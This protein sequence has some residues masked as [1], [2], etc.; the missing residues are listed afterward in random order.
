MKKLLI[1][2]A[3]LGAMVVGATAANAADIKAT[4]SWQIESDWTADAS[5]Q[6]KLKNNDFAI[7]QRIRTAFQFIANE[8][9]K[10]VLETQ[11]GTNNWGNGQ[12]QISAGRT[13]STTA[14]G[15][16]TAGA[17]NILLRKAY[18]DFKVPNTKVEVLA[19]YQ[20]IALPAAFGG[21]SAILDD[22]M[23]GIA[24]VVPV[25]DGFS[26]V[27]GYARPYDAN[28]AGSTATKQVAGTAIDA[29]LLYANIDTTGFSVKPFVAYASIGSS[30]VTNAL[31]SGGD[32]IGVGGLV[33]PGVAPT[34]GAR[35]YWG[36]AA[37]T[38][39][40]LDPFK[41]LADINYG[42]ETFNDTKSVKSGRSGWMGD[43]A[44]DYT[45]L[46]MVTPELFYAYSS[47]E[48]GNSQK[49]ERM[50]VV[51]G[52]NWAFGSFW[53]QGGDSVAYNGPYTS[54]SQNLGFWALGLSMKDIKLVDKL[55]HTVHVIYFKGT[56]NTAVAAGLN[57]NNG[58]GNVLTSKDHLVEVDVNSK[59]QLY[60]ALSLGLEL[61]YINA[62]FDKPTWSAATGTAQS[63]LSK[64]A[65]KAALLLNYSF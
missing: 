30:A 45:G 24:A 54:S 2:L 15:S 39:T 48:D 11:I 42:K 64:D 40:A 25:T 31:A 10:G 1:S 34:A 46:S 55:S 47:G 44:V 8:N 58:Y 53:M 17:G 49:S 27:A 32:K 9:L 22:H 37:F 33:T 38:M 3:V 60:D 5:L 35:A 13:P 63:Y 21:G 57:T 19:G 12:Y 62:S 36:G 6:D 29:A 50:P 20:S 7:Q 52:E 23:A 4:G 41:V 18:L 65:Y 14:A 61:G 59:Y 51:S 56:N 28:T 43:V 16:N 26:L